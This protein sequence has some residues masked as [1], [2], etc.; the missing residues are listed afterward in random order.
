MQILEVKSV[1]ETESKSVQE[2]EKALLESHAEEGNESTTEADDT[3]ST[4]EAPQTVELKE[5]DIISFMNNKYGKNIK[6]IDELNEAR[7]SSPELPED[8][9]AYWKYKQETGRSL[10]D[11]VELNRDFD[12][13]EPDKILRDYLV[14][15]E[16]GLDDEDIDFKM[17]DY[18]YDEDLDE[19]NDIRQIKILK[20]KAIAKAK[21]Y[22]ESEKEKYRIPLE[23]SGDSISDEDAKGLKE[24][25]QYIKEAKS[26]DQA[27]E[28]KQ[29]WF[30]QKT[31]DVFGDE[32][33]GFK[34][35]VDGDK[36]VTFSPGDA[37]EMMSSNQNVSKF[38]S[39]FL[40]KD[41]LLS[42]AEGY[43][44]AIATAIHSDKFAKHFY[45]LGKSAGTDELLQNTKNINMGS[46][47]VPEVTSKGG[48]QV[49]VVNPD[50]GSSLK[51]KSGKKH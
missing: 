13:A 5:E 27:E 30:T 29:D 2:T 49:R 19:E 28:R 51:F 26:F 9:S 22:F 40:D 39:K 1:G 17:E 47:N 38:I 8:V 24:Y 50:S 36:E 42:D 37:T 14:A 34:F 4:E 25:K 21:E 43:H 33:K 23:S 7:D 16:K 32:F 18:S 31:K 45:E 35:T 6:S 20:K 10:K 11:F 48:T 46:R 12:S 15:T 3:V 41:G 44:K